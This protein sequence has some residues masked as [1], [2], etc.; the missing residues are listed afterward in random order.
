MEGRRGPQPPGLAVNCPW[1]ARL[2]GAPLHRRAA[3]GW[4]GVSD[5]LC[6]R[7]PR[8]K[9]ISHRHFEL[10]S[11]ASVNQPPAPPSG[12][13]A[14][15]ASAATSPVLLSPPARSAAPTTITPAISNPRSCST[16]VLP[17]RRGRERQG[18]FVRT[19][20]IDSLETGGRSLPGHNR[21]LLDGRCGQEAGHLVRWW[22]APAN[23]RWAGL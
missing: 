3:W 15:S 23:R 22:K 17:H 13:Y 4:W 10:E 21:C 18:L 5:C 1:P 16:R 8:R 19:E 12:T 14:A 11:R 2:R 20:G 7:V 6:H 9:C